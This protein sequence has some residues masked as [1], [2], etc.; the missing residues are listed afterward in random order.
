MPLHGKGCDNAHDMCPGSNE[1]DGGHSCVNGGATLIKK[2]HLTTASCA[3]CN[4]APNQEGGAK[5]H[6]ES[7][8]QSCITKG[9]DRAASLDYAAGTTVDFAS[10]TDPEIMAQCNNVRPVLFHSSW[11]EWLE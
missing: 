9:L 8:H 6:I 4:T 5:L 3:Q 10:S 11:T 1:C 7:V 2:I